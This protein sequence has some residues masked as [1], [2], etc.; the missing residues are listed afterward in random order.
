MVKKEC[1]KNDDDQ[2]FLDEDFASDIHDKYKR[3]PNALEDLCLAE[4]AQWWKVQYINKSSLES[5]AYR[6][7]DSEE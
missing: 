7:S 2:E 1:L 3:R 4:F 6:S 5:L